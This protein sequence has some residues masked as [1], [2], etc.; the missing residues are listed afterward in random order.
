[1]DPVIQKIIIPVDFSPSSE[2]AARFG[3][4][5]AKKLGAHAYLLHVVAAPATQARHLSELSVARSGS[6]LRAHDAMRAFANRVDGG[7]VTST[8]VRRGDVLDG[9]RST[10]IAYGGDLVVMAAHGGA[11]R[12]HVLRGRMAEEVMRT[13]TCPVLVMRDSGQVQV[14]RRPSRRAAIAHYAR[15]A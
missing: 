13:V 10:V 5:L 3:C 1:M 12:P 11:D 15:T 8:E 4:A 7:A 2:R 9:I 14:H 6:Y